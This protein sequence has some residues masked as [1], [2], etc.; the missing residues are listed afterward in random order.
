MSR[1]ALFVMA[2]ICVTV[3]TVAAWVFHSDIHPYMHQH[4][5]VFLPLGAGCCIAAPAFM[6]R[7]ARMNGSQS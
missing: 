1:R 2:A 7:L 5:Y 4:W 6:A 3:G